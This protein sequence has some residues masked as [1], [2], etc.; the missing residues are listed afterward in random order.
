M[1]LDDVSESP[2]SD[3]SSQIVILLGA[4]GMVETPARG[5]QFSGKAASCSPAERLRASR[6]QGA[7]VTNSVDLDSIPPEMM[8]LAEET[9]M[10]HL[11]RALPPME[12]ITY[13]S[14]AEETIMVPQRTLVDVRTDRWVMTAEIAKMLIELA[15][16]MPKHDEDQAKL[17]EE[18]AKEFMLVST[19]AESSNEVVDMEW[20]T[21]VHYV[22]GAL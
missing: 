10:V 16:L 20:S 7:G 22:L 4:M 9:G 14:K 5:V 11:L 2:I 3:R 13:L 17:M 12:K 21:T 19:G 6:R 1:R 8:R 18:L 15:P